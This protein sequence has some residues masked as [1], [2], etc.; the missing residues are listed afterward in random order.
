VTQQDGWSASDVLTPSRPDQLTRARLAA[1]DCFCADAIVRQALDGII[2]DW[3]PTAERLYGYRAA[4]IIGQSL[5]RLVPPDHRAT[6]DAILRRVRRGECVEGIETV[7]WTKDHRRR[8][9][10][11][12]VFPVR[13]EADEVIATSAMVRD[14]T[15]Q[16]A[17]AASEE[18]YRVAFE[19]APM[20]MLV[21]DPE[22]QVVRVNHALIQMLGYSKDELLASTFWS[23][24]HPADIEPNRTYIERTLAGEIDRY[25]LEKRYL[26]RDGHVVCVHLTGLLVRDATGCPL[27]FISQIQDITERKAAEAE[28]VAIHQRS[29]QVLERITDGFYGLDRDWRFT[30]INDAAENILGRQLEELLGKNIWEEFP[31]ALETPLYRAYHQAMTEGHPVS[32]ELYGPPFDGLYEGQIYPSPDG[33]PVF[34]RD[35]TERKR[36]IEELRISEAKYRTLVEQLPGAVYL[37]AVD[38]KQTPLYFSPYIKELTGETP[39]EATAF[40]GHWL[41]LVHPEDCEHVAAEDARHGEMRELFRAEYRHRRMD[42]S[43]VWVRDEC[44]PVYDGDTVIAWQGVML[45][46]TDRR[47]AEEAQAHLAAIVESAEDAI[48]SSALD[49][50]ITSWNRGAEQL[51]GYTASEIIGR[52]FDLLLPADQDEL[53]LEQRIAAVRSGQPVAPF[54][55]TRRRKDATNVDVMISLSPVWDRN[56]T[57]VGASSITRDITERKRADAELREALEAAEAGI[58]AKTHFLRMMSH[59]LRTPLQAV[60]GYADFLFNDPSAFLTPEQREDVGYIYNGAIRMVALIEQMLDL[61]RM[62]AGRLELESERVDL[63]E[64]IEQVRQDVAPQAEAKG[65]RIEVSVPATLPPALGDPVRIRQILINLVGNAVKFTEQGSVSISGLTTKEGIELAVRDSG[66]GI[67]PEDL[68][69][70]F[71]EFHQVDRRL[72][73]RYGGAGLGL[74]I[75][76]RLAE[77]MGG[78]ITVDSVP[79]AG[80]EFTLRL[81]PGSVSRTTK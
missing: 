35:I 29:R 64:I 5:G 75:S 65:L 57:V 2:T 50:T 36:L 62:E 76:R 27:Y 15:D 26:H 60:L 8:D 54:E 6:A 30:Y 23:H 72:S 22:L 4:E 28:L 42:G 33:L 10:R 52:R 51:F 17:A 45:D 79:N 41:D 19:S 11:L 59:E 49:G 61:S 24:T 70:I 37:L 67:K 46:I 48:I 69:D 77:Q 1:L 34:F 38:E 43:Y 25:S 68:P 56:G 66:I 71:E 13:N 7:H 16:K 74:A 47:E 12:T 31:P 78:T 20:G 40:R 80:S 32:I 55:T 14:I 9:V 44:V 21:T 81:I 73:R 63:A 18:L 58:Q 39:E 3:N 53:L